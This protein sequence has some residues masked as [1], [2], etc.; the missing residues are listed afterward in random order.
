[1]PLASETP[2]SGERPVVTVQGAD[3]AAASDAPSTTAEKDPMG[4]RN[5]RA[6]IAPMSNLY[7]AFMVVAGAAVAAQIAINAH[8]SVV[9]GGAL[10]AANISF[11]VTMAVG[12]VAL[13]VAMALGVM[14]LPDPAV[15]SAPRWI[16]LGGLGGATYVLLA[17]L[18]THRIG[19]ALLAAAGILGQLGTSLLIDHYGWFG[20]PVQRLSAVRLIGVVLLTAGVVLI[21]WK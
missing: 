18:L 12:L 4:I 15:W 3:W 19:A 8:L 10:W 20:V 5:D 7:I 2:A 16:W 6:I 13:G 11:A 9:T 17:I 1:M 21:R 14:S